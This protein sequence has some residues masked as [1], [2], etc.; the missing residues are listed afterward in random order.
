MIVAIVGFR[1]FIHMLIYY[2]D[3]S[4]LLENR[5]QMKIIRNY[6]RDRRNYIRHS[7]PRGADI[8]SFTKE[9]E[10]TNMKEE[11]SHDLKQ[12]KDCFLQSRLRERYS[13][14]SVAKLQEYHDQ[15]FVLSIRC[16]SVC[17]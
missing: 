6:I 10:N 16:S 17:L 1:L 12:F 9:Q 11:S 3:V 4:V 15:G 7:T 14:N 8:E 5:P 2:I 13:R